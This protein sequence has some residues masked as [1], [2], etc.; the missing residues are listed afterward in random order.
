MQDDSS[1]SLISKLSVCN[2]GLGRFSELTGVSSYIIGSVL[3]EGIV[4]D[5]SGTQSAVYEKVFI[6][7]D[8]VGVDVQNSVASLSV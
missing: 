4:A 5:I 7:D 8:S 3:V 2:E 1:S 6:L